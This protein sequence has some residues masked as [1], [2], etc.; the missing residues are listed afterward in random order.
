MSF[1][2]CHITC[3]AHGNE[4]YCCKWMRHVEQMTESHHTWMSHV[5]S[6]YQERAVEVVS[7]PAS[8]KVCTLFANSSFDSR[9]PSLLP[10][11]LNIKSKR[12]FWDRSYKQIYT[13]L[14]AN[15]SLDRR[16]LSLLALALDITSRRLFWD[17]PHKYAHK[18]FCVYDVCVFCVWPWWCHW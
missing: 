15:S 5:A 17:G 2:E 14:L 1:Y 11:A 13:T 7:W 6:K 9:A 10:P 12:S 4:S 18:C 3:N 16:A 8:K